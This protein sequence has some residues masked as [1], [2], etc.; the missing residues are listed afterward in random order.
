M[1]QVRHHRN[2]LKTLARGVQVLSAFTPGQPSLSLSQ[3]AEAMSLD[4][5]TVYRFVSTLEHLGY[6]RRDPAAR[7]YS[8]T[9]R[10]LDLARAV[11]QPDELLTAARPYLEELAQQTE[12]TVEL[13]V[14]DGV[15][16]I[17]VATIES[18]Q[19]VAVRGWV[20]KHLPT[21][22]TAQ[23]KVLLASL[24]PL[25]QKQL[26]DEMK[27]EAFGPNTITS[28]AALERELR[29]TA[30][31]GYGLNDNEMNIGIQAIAA[32][33]RSHIGAVVAALGV[34]MPIGRMSVNEMEAQLAKM[35]MKYAGKISAALGCKPQR[36]S[37]RR[38]RATSSINRR[39]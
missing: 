9:S 3:L 23:G 33:I 28:Q 31:R 5:A 30:S 36:Q 34:A 39:V 12:E 18:Q 35:V 16:L 14:R 11:D 24:S 26:L 8:L 38:Q 19:R 37:P 10:V 7:T 13:A 22:V 32:P 4:P 1:S 20:G 17:V 25:E 6:L 2:Y 29:L 21:Y 15:S 27:L